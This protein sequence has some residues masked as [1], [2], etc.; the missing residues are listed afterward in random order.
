[1]TDRLDQQARTTKEARFPAQLLLENAGVG[2]KIQLNFQKQVIF[3]QG[4]PA[5][6]LFYIREGRVRLTLL[7]SEGKAATIT[8]LGEGEFLGE[9]CLV[10]SHSVRLASA[11]AITNCCLVKIGKDQ[12][13]AALESDHALAASFTQY[14]LL[15]KIHAEDN[16]AHQIFHSSEKRLVRLLLLL[17]GPETDGGSKRKLPEIS[18]ETLAEMVGTTRPRISYFMAKFRKLGL[19]DY[20]RGLRVRKELQ[21]ILR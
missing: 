1:M 10:P 5:P 3:S 19:V 12:M 8:I 11:V 17:A 6:T 4:D 2:A 21:N 13:L 20:R 18:Q 16:L 14:L 7:S 9:E 15:R